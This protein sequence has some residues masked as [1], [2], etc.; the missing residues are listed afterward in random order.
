MAC[1][2][3]KISAERKTRERE[4]ERDLRERAREEGRCMERERERLERKGGGR[5]RAALKIDNITVYLATTR[6]IH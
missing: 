6:Q 2:Q 1:K 4:R 3:A 5:E